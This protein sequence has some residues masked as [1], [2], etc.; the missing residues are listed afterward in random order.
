MPSRIPE[1]IKKLFIDGQKD[2]A[3]GR[4]ESALAKFQDVIA[5]FRDAGISDGL[6]ET[7]YQMAMVQNKLGQFQ[8]AAITLKEALDLYRFLDRKDRISI[9]LHALGMVYAELGEDDIAA[10]FLD[11]AGDHYRQC[12]DESGVAACFFEVGNIWLKKGNLDLARQFYS[13][14]SPLLEFSGDAVGLGKI[15]YMEAIIALKQDEMA[16]AFKMLD[17]AKNVFTRHDVLDGRI[18]VT[19]L[20][21]LIALK[22][23][24]QNKASLLFKDAMRLIAE[25]YM[26]APGSSGVVDK[27]D[28]VQ[29]L[30][31]LGNLLVED[32]RGIPDIGNTLNIKAYQLFEEAATLAG[33]LDYLKGKCLALF[34]MG[35]ILYERGD[36]TNLEESSSMF[37]SAYDLAKDINDKEL[38]TR[39]LLFLGVNNRLLDE[40]EKALTY[41]QDCAVLSKNLGYASLE[42]RAFIERGKVYYEMGFLDQSRQLI[43]DGIRLV[44]SSDQEQL[45]D[46]LAEM[47]V[48][49]SYI[50]LMSGETEIALDALQNSYSLHQ[51]RGNKHAMADTLKELARLYEMQG[52]IPEAIDQVRKREAI[53]QETNELR[54]WSR[55]REE[56]AGLLFKGGNLDDAAKLLSDLLDLVDKSGMGDVDDIVTG[57]NVILY[58]IWK[59]KGDE[60]EAN[61]I[62]SNLL[63]YYE[64]NAQLN[65]FFDIMVDIAYESIENNNVDM[66]NTAIDKL[67]GLVKA[68]QVELSDGQL[69]AFLH[70]SGLVCLIKGQ[71][72]L[73]RLHLD[74]CLTIV[75][76]QGRETAQGVLLAQI[77]EISYTEGKRDALS[78]FSEA[79]RILPEMV[80]RDELSKIFTKLATIEFELGNVEPALEHAL[81]AIRLFE[82]QFIIE[83]GLH[84]VHK[85]SRENRFIYHSLGHIDHEFVSLLNLVRFM[86]KNEEIFL[87]RAIIALQFKKIYKHHAFFDT[88]LLQMYS[89]GENG[90]AKFIDADAE[91]R[92]K[93]RTKD[94]LIR[95]LGD[96]HEFHEIA[97]HAR[98]TSRQEFTKKVLDSIKGR[99]AA[100]SSDLEKILVDVKKNRASLMECQDPGSYV[101]FI[102]FNI[103]NQCRRVLKGHEDSIFL[104]YT[105]YGKI[106]KLVVFMIHSD[107][108]EVVMTDVGAEF[109]SMLEDIDLAIGDDDQPQVVV[110][111]Q[112]ITRFLFPPRIQERITELGVNNIFICIDGILEN[113]RFNLLGEENDLSARFTFIHVQSMLSMKPVLARDEIQGKDL[114]F[115]LLYPDTNELVFEDEAAILESMFIKYS[116]AGQKGIRS[117]LLRDMKAG[118]SSMQDISKTCPAIIHVGCE[119]YIPA[120][121][122]MKGFFTMNDRPYMVENF[123][124]LEMS[125]NNGLLCLSSSNQ[126]MPSIDQVLSLWRTLSFNNCPNLLF[127][128]ST[129]GFSGHFFENMYRHLISGG[130]LGDA[131]RQGV[132]SVQSMAEATPLSRGNLVFVGNPHW[133]L[134][135]K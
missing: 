94:T 135:I 90:L 91:L 22:A 102:G 54:D 29:I 56:L 20:E 24:D 32:A 6:A 25:R 37:L 5:R 112:K 83:E 49:K 53:L 134:V 70:V 4:F 12:G 45:M 132:K 88:S 84:G 40:H 26:K 76:K 15:S 117:V 100:E 63:G 121:S 108:I 82:D 109:F 129:Y 95:F 48:I 110:L 92:A 124:D 104:D 114:D 120:T 133:K 34:N 7:L 96:K 61:V 47:F 64:Q 52:F 50:Y 103:I 1:M 23:K 19:V 43:E 18:K 93:A 27:Q 59:A 11:D 46:L 67:W 41:L 72:D 62:F 85:S 119:S 3:S 126:L 8:D 2:F 115:Y 16:E 89:C 74:E 38:L 51:S 122:P 39:S 78:L 71:H 42:A 105:V 107:Q 77:G 35:L 113:I 79:A 116:R 69:V 68:K 111:H 65:A 57:A 55:A 125:G 36:K 131:I 98:G 33:N 75:K 9:V 28:E 86:E 73:A 17:S 99:I 14:A 13:K 80:Y 106:S 58:K 123:L 127:M 101:P 30:I 44:K 81:H 118:Y 128:S 97:L 10:R 60:I 31:A 66:V 21:A 130:S 87:N